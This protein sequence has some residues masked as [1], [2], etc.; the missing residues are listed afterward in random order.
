MS[1]FLDVCVI[2]IK[3]IIFGTTPQVENDH[4]GGKTRNKNMIK[5]NKINHK[6]L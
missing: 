5:L 3:N 6:L 1:K 4:A 2:K